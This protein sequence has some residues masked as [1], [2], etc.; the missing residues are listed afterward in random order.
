MNASDNI[1]S[2]YPVSSVQLG[3]LFQSLVA[4]GSGLYIVQFGMEF[5]PGIDVAALRAAWEAVT[6]RHSALRTLFIRLDTRQPLQVVCRTV[7]LAWTEL[8]WRDLAESSVE[9]TLR[10]FL[11]QD[12][13]RDFAYASAPLMRLTLVRLPGGRHRLVWTRHHAIADG[14]S[15]PIVLGDVLRAYEALAARTLPSFDAAR[16]FKDYV[17]W[18]LQQD[19][20]AA[21]AYWC[22]ELA[23]A[24]VPTIVGIDRGEGRPVEHVQQFARRDRLLSRSLTAD[25]EALCRRERLTLGTLVQG[26]WALLLWR[27]GGQPDVVFGMVSAGRPA[28]LDDADRIVGCM[29]NTVPVRV[30]LTPDTPLLAWLDSLKARDYERE[31]HA[32]A[33]L[34]RLREWSGLPADTALLTSLV[35]VE[36]FPIP[37]AAHE[38]ARELGVAN[39]EMAEQTSLPLTL[40]V[41]PGEQLA[42]GLSYATNR[43]DEADVERALSHLVNL[44]EQ[45]ATEPRRALRTLSLLGPADM[46]AFL[47]ESRAEPPQV[48]ED[49]HELFLRQAARTPDAIALVAGG[50]RV[51]YGA[52]VARCAVV[53]AG[54]RR[55]GVAEGARV[56]LAMQRGVELVESMLA[57]LACGA[58]YVPIDP[59]YPAARIAWVVEDSAP[60]VILTDESSRARLPAGARLVDVREF[61][62]LEPDAATGPRRIPGALP[63]YFIYTSG[64]TGRPKGVE[65]SRASASDFVRWA[66]HTYGAQG[67]AYTLASSSVC[68]D[69]SIFEVFAPLACGGAV[70]MVANALS[71]GDVDVPV[72]LINTVPSVMDN[73]LRGGLLPSVRIVNL[74]GEPCSRD[75]VDRLYATAAIESV[76][77][78]YGP[79]EDTTYS[80]AT[81]VPRGSV[82]KPSIGRSL[83]GRYGYVLAADGTPLPTNIAGELYLGGTGLANGYAGDPER[84]AERFVPDP[85]GLQPGARLYRTGDL[86]RRLEDGNLEYLGRIDRQVKI[87]GFRIEPAEIESVLRRQPGVRDAVVVTA[88]SPAGPDLVAF[89]VADGDIAALRPFLAAQLPRYMLPSAIHPVAAIPLSPNGKI[90]QAALLQ[91]RRAE[92]APPAPS[93]L[94]RGEA[95]TRVAQVWAEV[96]GVASVGRHDAFFDIGGNSLMLL[97]VQGKLSRL[98][99]QPLPVAELFKYPTV[100]ELAAYLESLVAPAPATRAS[101]FSDVSDRLARRRMAQTPSAGNRETGRS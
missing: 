100:H 70:V 45:M 3:M 10:E 59:A 14:W 21:R 40:S 37:A 78:L 28:S 36:N 68:F 17:A 74:A 52:L 47:A 11:A 95:E 101:A 27:Y 34:T 90:D 83:P 42:L 9:S 46:V 4:P 60:H 26:A 16:P 67:L 29:V 38:T 77:N 71:L 91:L 55:A 19:R 57:T 79:S 63:A 25:L 92:T 8:D 80:T 75:L 44:F 24:P 32:H 56:G 18:Q 53:A 69:L 6:A 97:E 99:A 85:F 35:V 62:D 89:V 76:Y 61:V 23:G 82:L 54:L 87:R 58:A 33:P 39:M 88:Q 65:I 22:D 84:T 81:L 41:A 86:V 49:L 1:E 72:S 31:E 13:A 48:G 30:R 12:R 96:V 94:P 51:S 20:E 15:L 2:I 7:T 66:A 73:L 98:F 93:T 43:F 50:R 64:S 5:G